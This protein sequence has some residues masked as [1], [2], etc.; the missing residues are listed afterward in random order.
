MDMQK[1]CIYRGEYLQKPRHNKLAYSRVP[2]GNVILFDM[3]FPNGEFASP[4]RLQDEARIL[5]LECVPTLYEGRAHLLQDELK[6]YLLLESVLGGQTIEGIVIKNYYQTDQQGKPLMGKLVSETF[7]ESHVKKSIR[8]DG[9][10]IEE[11]LAGYSREARWSKAVQHL[12]EA[13]ELEQS[14]KDIGPLLKE[15]SLDFE[16]ECEEEIKNLL[17][18]HFRKQIIKG[19]CDGF[20]MWYKDYLA[21]GDA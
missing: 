14:P 9:D 19:M 8:E 5:N 18:A 2:L 6:S 3:E 12:Q 4:Q 7:R 21:F 1:G 13:G 20:A 16:K 17:Y 10:V 11:I 15:M